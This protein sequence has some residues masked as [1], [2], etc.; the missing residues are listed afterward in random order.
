[1]GRHK[2]DENDRK[3]EHLNL[4]LRTV[5]RVSQLLNKERDLQKLIQGIC[6]ILVANRGYHNAW[7]ALLDE[8][9]KFTASAEAGVGEKYTSM[10]QSLTRGD[11]TDCIRKALSQPGVVITRDPPSACRNCPLSEA[12][13]GRGAITV[14]LEY[15]QHIYGILTI[16]IPKKFITDKEEQELVQEI[17]ND[18]VRGIDKIEKEKRRKWAE[19]AFQESEHR[20]RNLVE[21][22]LTGISIIQADR[23]VYQNP[24]QERL[25]G[26]L[27][28]QTI[29]A[30]LEGIHPDDI[31]KVKRLYQDITSGKSQ[32]F[33]TDF[34]FYPKTNLSG[35]QK[36]VWVNCRASAI[37]YHGKKAI[38]VNVMDVTRI[39][40]L[41]NL[42]RVQDKMI[43]LGR[44]AAGI[45]H[46]IRNPLSGINIYLNTL[47]KIFEKE[48]CPQ[49]VRGILDHLKSASFKIESVIKR[50]M[51]FAKPGEPKFVWTDINKPVEEAISLSS[52]T[53]RKSGIKIEKKLTA[54]LPKCNIDPHMIEEV[55]LNLITNAAEAMKRME[56]DKRILVESFY[57]KNRIFLTVSDSGP[58]VSL[59]IKDKIF[60]PFYTTK[61]G[62]AGIGLSLSQRIIADHGGSISV[63]AS[64]WGGAQ[65]R[66]EIPIKGS[67]IRN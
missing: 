12:Y 1:M 43:S 9:G 16:S 47:E 4:V 37:E 44:V 67:G 11:L 32:V 52:V 38:L 61:T 42:L 13:S 22:S 33:E 35:N 60:D 5:R 39:R 3:L 6:D 7:I 28:R 63:T 18:I 10:V 19:E 54:D 56:K 24:E 49:K 46:E 64:K 50:V 15:D 31:E 14:R 48:Q 17:G 57:R 65:F 21:N 41:E 51:D 55:V 30:S 25:F 2:I 8:S 20:F 59:D 26:P 45:A 27:P 58:G 62:G 36:L 66:I 40:Q 29:L 34:R 23:I 53:M